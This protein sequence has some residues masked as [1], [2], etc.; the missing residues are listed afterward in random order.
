MTGGLPEAGM[1]SEQ[2]GGSELSGRLL[3]FLKQY[4]LSKQD[5][6]VIAMLKDI[7]AG[8]RAPRKLGNWGSVSADEVD[9][10]LEA[11]RQW[12]TQGRPGMPG[13][14]WSRTYSQWLECVVIRQ[15]P[16]GTLLLGRDVEASGTA[17]YVHPSGIPENLEAR[18]VEGWFV[19]KEQASPEMP[20]EQVLR[21]IA[22]F[23]GSTIGPEYLALNKGDELVFSHQEDGWACGRVLR[24]IGTARLHHDLQAGWYPPDYARLQS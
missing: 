15:N 16:D 19:P 24:R 18:E 7:S 11:F 23:D 10:A 9:G 14:Y 12:K 4:H 8:G 1:A 6:A 17:D 3:S 13:R 22:D 5:D 20:K 21:V 2:G